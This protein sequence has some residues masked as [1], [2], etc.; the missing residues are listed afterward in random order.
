MERFKNI[1]SH[2]ARHIVGSTSWE[3]YSNESHGRGEA[4]F[5]T[6]GRNIREGTLDS[7]KMKHIFLTKVMTAQEARIGANLDDRPNVLLLP[8][9]G[10]WLYHDVRQFDY[11][12]EETW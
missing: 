1:L 12:K 2:L 7:V 6:E 11:G 9:A 3:R 10:S 4:D 5:K 8:Q